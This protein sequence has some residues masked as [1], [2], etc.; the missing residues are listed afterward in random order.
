[1]PIFFDLTHIRK[2]RAEIHKKIWLIAKDRPKLE[3]DSTNFF[4]AFLEYIN[5]IVNTFE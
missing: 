4:V 5:S 1:M 2:A 3:K